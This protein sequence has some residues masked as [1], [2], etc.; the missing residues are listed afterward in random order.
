MFFRGGKKIFA[1]CLVAAA[2]AVHCAHVE[3]GF[4]GGSSVA[5]QNSGT[6]KYNVGNKS[7]GT[8]RWRS[9]RRNRNKR[10]YNRG[11]GT[12]NSSG[13]YKDTTGTDTVDQVDSNVIDTTGTTTPNTGG[14]N[15]IDTMDTLSSNTINGTDI[16]TNT[17]TIDEGT[18]TTDTSII[19]EGTDISTDTVTTD[20][21]I[22]GGATTDVSTYDGAPSTFSGAA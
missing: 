22:T 11:A 14:N 18:P 20:A 21:P 19:D 10:Y 6:R 13:K 8:Q 16:S 17:S 4:G 15:V 9:K 12:Q 2:I 1:V 5:T 7:G 3:A